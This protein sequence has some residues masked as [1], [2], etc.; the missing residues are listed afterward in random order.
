MFAER[1][2]HAFEF[3]FCER[4]YIDIGGSGELS[5][6]LM[7]Q[8]VASRTWEPDFDVALDKLC[9]VPDPA[10]YCEDGVDTFDALM[11]RT[12][13]SLDGQWPELLPVLSIPFDKLKVLVDREGYRFVCGRVTDFDDK[14]ND[15]TIHVLLEKVS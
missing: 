9:E 13:Q 5:E 7:Q 2:L 4:E 14:Y 6:Q 15:T 12:E 8:V 10:Y 1:S 3:C 11:A